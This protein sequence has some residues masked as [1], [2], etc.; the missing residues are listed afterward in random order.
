MEPTLV[1]LPLLLGGAA[2]IVYLVYR[3]VYCL[4]KKAVRDAL[5]EYEAEKGV[6]LTAKRVETAEPER[7]N[8][9]PRTKRRSERE[10]FRP[11][12][13][14]KSAW[15]RR[16]MQ[17]RLPWRRENP[18]KAPDIPWFWTLTIDGRPRRKF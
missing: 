17:M 14:E 4:V 1:A 2:L 9:P 10:F 8:T 7:G 3:I 11:A 15:K 5:R 18:E 12:G 16:R 13:Q 6:A